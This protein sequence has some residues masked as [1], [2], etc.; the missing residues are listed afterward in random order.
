MPTHTLSVGEPTYLL[1]RQ[2]QKNLEN[3]GHVA[4]MNRT[5]AYLAAFH[6]AI[7][8]AHGEALNEN[9][10][11]KRDRIYRDALMQA[12]GNIPHGGGRSKNRKSYSASLEMRLIVQKMLMDRFGIENPSREL[13]NE[14]IDRGG[15]DNMTFARYEDKAKQVVDRFADLV[16]GI[17]TEYPKPLVIEP[18]V[19]GKVV[20]KDD[21][22]GLKECS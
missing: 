1:V 4:S 21:G 22:S 9:D 19:E 11:V 20:E 16:K 15:V 10:A 7:V 17:G 8:Q 2:A 5:I 6:Q 12:I 13:V 14:V 3:R 18:P